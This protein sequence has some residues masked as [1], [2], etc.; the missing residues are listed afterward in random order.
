MAASGFGSFFNEPVHVL[1]E[2]D[3]GVYKEPPKPATVLAIGT[4]LDDECRSLESPT[5]I[6]ERCFFLSSSWTF[7]NHGAFG[8]TLRC[9]SRAANAWQEYTESQVRPDTT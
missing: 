1:I 7:I 5:L 8:A 3:D 6:R 2:Q 4:D 9:A